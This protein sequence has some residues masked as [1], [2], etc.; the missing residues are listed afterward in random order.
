MNINTLYKFYHPLEN[1]ENVL[2][3]QDTSTTLTCGDIQTLEEE[4]KFLE[5]TVKRDKKKI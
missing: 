2:I 5:E 1:R 4:C 3:C